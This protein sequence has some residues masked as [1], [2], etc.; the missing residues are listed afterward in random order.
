MERGPDTQDKAE[1]VITL[2]HRECT[3]G[4]YLYPETSE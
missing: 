2:R 1:S 3:E 4:M